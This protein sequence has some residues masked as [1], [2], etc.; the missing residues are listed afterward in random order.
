[1]SA[2]PFFSRRA[3]IGFV[4]VS[5]ALRPAGSAAGETYIGIVPGVGAGGYDVVAYF[6]ENRPMKGLATI[7]AEWRGA[8]WRFTTSDR[9]NRFMADPERYAPSYGGYCS[10]AAAQGYKAKGDPRNWR[11]VSGRLFLNYDSEI[12]QRWE[13]DIAGHISRA[14]GNW[15]DLRHR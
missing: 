4:A 8:V 9:R 2:L 11:I 14:D 10:W 13:A 15:P 3:L 7:T 12:Q 6:D 1:M 5:A